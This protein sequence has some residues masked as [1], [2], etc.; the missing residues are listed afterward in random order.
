MNRTNIV[1]IGMPGCGKST[2]GILLAKQAGLDFI[3][4]D[5]AIQTHTG[6]SLQSIVDQEGHIVLREIEERVILGLHPRKHVIATG[7]SAVYSEPAMA[8]LKTNGLIVYLQARIETL[9]ERVKD[10]AARGLA[11]RPGQDFAS[12]YAERMPLYERCAEETVPCDHMN[13]E[14]V[15]AAVIRAWRQRNPGS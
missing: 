12:L 7:G 5:V 3:D 2:V 4:T 9:E 14:D 8:H 15:C 10:F 11:K 13:H 1:L 6:R